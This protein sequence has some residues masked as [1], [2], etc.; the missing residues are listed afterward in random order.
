VMLDFGDDKN[1]VNPPYLS[2]LWEQHLETI[3]RN[4]AMVTWSSGVLKKLKGYP[5]KPRKTDRVDFFKSTCAASC[6]PF[7]ALSF[8]SELL[9]PNNTGNR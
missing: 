1:M 2:Y 9:S 3:E 5:K 7:V 4:R 6:A 8:S